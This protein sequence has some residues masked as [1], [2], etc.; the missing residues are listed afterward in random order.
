MNFL[1]KLVGSISPV[2]SKSAWDNAF[3]K[4]ISLGD[5]NVLDKPYSKSTLVY[6]I[7]STTA[8]AIAQVPL[9]VMEPSS[10]AKAKDRFNIK[11]EAE[12]L[13]SVGTQPCIKKLEK[14]VKSGEL[15]P[16]SADNKYQML[17]NHPNHL[18]DSYHFKEKL[19]GFTMLDGNV[20]SYPLPSIENPDMIFILKKSNMGY[21]KSDSGQVEAWNYTP[22]AQGGM[23]IE[24]DD[25]MH[26]K[27]W[28][29]YCEIMGAVPLDAGKVETRTDYKA[30][31]YNEKFFDNGAVAGNVLQTDKRLNDST[32]KRIKEGIQNNHGGVDK[33]HKMMIFEQGLK[34]IQTGLTQRDMEFIDLRKYSR[35]QIMGI[36]G[37][38][39]VVISVTETVNHATAKEQR[40]EWWQD[41]NL[42]LMRLISSTYNNCIFKKTPYLMW[43]DTTTIEAL[44][45]DFNAKVETGERLFK[46]GFSTNEINSRLELGFEDVA[47]RNGMYIP[48]GV[49]EIGSIVEESEEPEERTVKGIED[50]EKLATKNWKNFIKAN[51]P[52]EKAYAKKVSKIFFGIRNKVLNH[53][54]GKD[55]KQV[56]MVS[57]E[58]MLNW[59]DDVNRDVEKDVLRKASGVA[60]RQAAD[61]GG[62]S[63]ID[64][65][66]L[67]GS[68]DIDD[69]IVIDFLSAKNI[70]V[71]DIIDTAY[72]VVRDGITTGIANGESIDQIADRIKSALKGNINRAKTIARTEVIGASNF[73]RNNQMKKTDYTQKQWFTAADERVRDTSISSHVSMNGNITSMGNGWIVPGAGA[74][75]VRYPGDYLGSPANIINCRC[76]EVVVLDS[77]VI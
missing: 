27:L 44:Q 45:E 65:L 21:E 34:Y 2:I 9:R 11:A 48:M 23:R 35:E 31:K 32:L 68:F 6:T 61:A 22:S 71:T 40:K 58:D 30:S 7:I 25:I 64:E 59:I 67:S 41:T 43:W 37:M 12:M 42:P 51:T 77:L 17:L 47:A 3:L 54:Y 63:V 13:M 38:K 1:E 15:Q 72:D 73:G 10:T 33:A 20:W 26:T 29:P 50:W 39:N 24:N 57:P 4:N 70:K 16:V 8:R 36:Y 66:G 46:M 28:N 19:I 49:Q 75:F 5:G 56:P 60:H 52:I 18:D 69:P 53:L 14:M 74:G 76:I 62:N 55:T